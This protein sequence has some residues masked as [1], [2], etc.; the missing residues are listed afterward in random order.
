MRRFEVVVI[1][2]AYDEALLRLN[3]SGSTAVVVFNRPP[4]KEARPDID[5]R[6]NDEQMKP[7]GMNTEPSAAAKEMTGAEQD[8]PTQVIGNAPA[9][10][11]TAVTDRY[12]SGNGLE[13]PNKFSTTT[14]SLRWPL[15]QHPMCKPSCRLTP[16]DNYKA[17]S[18][19]DNTWG[20]LMNKASP[21]KPQHE[22]IPAGFLSEKSIATA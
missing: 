21:V 15:V 2:H 19:L 22:H 18:A 10:S 6:A 11:L 12:T 13:M 9:P 20:L 8:Q 4:N 7:P 14:S 16:S 5:Q 17:S 3:M 1:G